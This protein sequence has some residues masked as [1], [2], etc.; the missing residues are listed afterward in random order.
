MPLPLSQWVSLPFHLLSLLIVRGYQESIHLVPTLQDK[1]AKEEEI[2]EGGTRPDYIGPKKR[3][4]LRGQPRARNAGRSGYRVPPV[5]FAT[6]KVSRTRDLIASSACDCW[7]VLLHVASG[8]ARGFLGR[9]PVT[10]MNC[11]PYNNTSFASTTPKFLPS[12][13][14]IKTP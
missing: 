11:L 14:S 4:S 8:I 9:Q 6:G 7:G 5:R 12:K 3:V 2:E 10:L 1:R 13:T